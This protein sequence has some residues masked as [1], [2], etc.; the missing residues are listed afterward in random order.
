MRCTV[1][2]H[3]VEASVLLRSRAAIKLIADD[4]LFSGGQGY[5]ESL[6]IGSWTADSA[7]N[8]QLARTEELVSRSTSTFLHSHDMQTKPPYT[9]DGISRHPSV[10]LAD[11]ARH[12]P[13]SKDSETIR[14]CLSISSVL[15]PSSSVSRLTIHVQ[16]NLTRAGRT[17]CFE[18]FSRKSRNLSLRNSIL[19]HQRSSTVLLTQLHRSKI[20]Q[21]RT[22][23]PKQYQNHNSVNFVTSLQLQTFVTDQEE[24]RSNRT[25][26]IS[27]NNVI[28]ILIDY[29]FLSLA[30]L[31]HR[32]KFVITLRRVGRMCGRGGEGWSERSMLESGSVH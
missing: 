19:L 22:E 4:S 9:V 12:L 7:G 3:C 14:K 1:R 8:R 15:S 26:H 27:Q 2:D 21:S 17:I 11:A 32:R 6:R 18:N 28:L 30:F 20:S 13:R 25:P 24:Y 5:G 23:Q 10:L 16:W 29:K 31:I